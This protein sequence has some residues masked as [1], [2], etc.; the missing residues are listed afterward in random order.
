MV[1]LMSIFSS[2]I[3]EEYLDT[4]LERKV[5]NRRK[6]IFL[7]FF[8]IW[9]MCT[10]L[11]LLK[12][13]DYYVL[14]LNTFIVFCM[15]Y[16]YEGRVIK[17]VVFTV[18]YNSL[19]LLM[20]VVLVYIFIAVKLDY[21]AQGMLGSLF[22]KLLL[23]F[24][25]KA[26]KYFFGNERIKELSHSYNMILLLFP[27]GSIFVVYTS[28]LM[29]SESQ[30]LQHVIWSFSSLMI[31]FVI[32]ILI[33]TI[34]L[35]LSDDL[36]LRQKNV[37]YKQ[38]I[39]FYNK[40]IEEKENSMQEFRKA[41]HDLKNQLILM[42]EQCEKKEYGELQDFLEKLIEKAPFDRLILSKT[43]NAVVDALINYKYSIAK[44]FGIDFTVKLDIPM[45]LPFDNADMCII[46]GNTLDNALEANIG[47]VID[48]P[49][50]KLIMRM[51]SGNLIIIVE[52]SFNGQIIKDKKGRIMTTKSNK[53]EHGLGLNSVQQSV[54]KYHGFMKASSDD[55]V[56]TVEILLYGGQK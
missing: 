54:D 49:Y 48:R 13:P 7:G 37:L 41:K 21:A 6:K 51:D 18:I 17:K 30:K 42:L 32:N 34:Y 29:S 52:N 55:N 38:E 1:F 8:I 2:W 44:R 25:V 35:K 14:A 3:L 28:F 5:L 16:N 56:F 23:F 22:S 11:D 27:L 15:T 26:L 31:I 4:F 9:Q 19:W 12:W 36:E 50:I 45:K 10:I 20:E 39:D 46:L 43:D 40:Y 53:L 47:S 24:L 33:F